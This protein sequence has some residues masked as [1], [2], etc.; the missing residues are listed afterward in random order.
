M[1]INLAPLQF[2]NRDLLH[3]LQSHLKT[4][5]SASVSIVDL[6][7]DMNTAYFKEREQYY[8]TRLIA[9]AI[10]V[11]KDIEDKVLLVTEHDLFVPVFTF[12]FGEA[13]LNGK[14]AIV[15]TTRLH[16]EFYSGVS[17]EP[18]LQERTLKEVM[19]ELGHTFGLIHCKN[20][21]CAMHTSLSVEEI[22][23][24]GTFYCDKC[25]KQ[26]GVTQNKLL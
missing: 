13:Q 2:S 4:I 21:E 19:H 8:S 5:F 17:N 22:D 20:W 14:H 1:K 18:L 15:S 7:I 6:P 23:I 26:A 11:T 9:E 10:K 25:H 12:L 3:Y 24:K 16:E